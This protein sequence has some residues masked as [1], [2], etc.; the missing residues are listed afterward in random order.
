MRELVLKMH[1]SVDGF[2]AGPAG[3]SDWIFR[4]LDEP[5]T[6]WML[7][8]LWQAGVHI[9]GSH[10]FL[11]MAAWWPVSPEPQA[12]P[13]NEIPKIVFSK[14]KTLPH[15]EDG[16]ANPSLEGVARALEA[17]DMKPL[18]LPPSSAKSWNEA[19]VASGELADEIARL[20]SQ[21]G[22]FILAHGGASFAQSL[23][24]LG[25]ID[26]YRLLIHPVAL[27]KGLPLFSRLARQ[28]DL[29][30][31]NSVAFNLGVIANI[32]RPKK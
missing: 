18:P 27:G 31:V 13:M 20:K 7:D 21:S 9:M 28:V 29:R 4:S 15:R 5:A 26:E 30:L 11:D 2:V 12:A 14:S 24:R 23:A 17:R 25:L 16:R 6:N 32:Y 10:A 22:K 8:T 3:E 19:R 1:V